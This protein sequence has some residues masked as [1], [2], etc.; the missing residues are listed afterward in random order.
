MI[1]ICTTGRL[2]Y[3]P[4][5]KTAK[6]GTTFC[7]F[8][9]A[10]NTFKH[11]E[12]K[13]TYFNCSAFGSTAT[14]VNNYFNKGKP[15][16]VVGELTLR[17]YQTKDRQTRTSAD[18]RVFDVSFA[19]SSKSDGEGEK[20]LTSDYRPVSEGQSPLDADFSELPF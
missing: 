4:E 8:K 12:K 14:Y 11:G 3:D 10:A 18:V 5:M 19:P 2:V 13:T 7:S 16:E 15:V 20:P 9:I 6:N 1:T 17:E